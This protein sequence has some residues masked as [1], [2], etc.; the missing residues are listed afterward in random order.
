MYHKKIF[1]KDQESVLAPTLF[2][3]YINDIENDIE[4]ED[5]SIRGKDLD[6]IL[7]KVPNFNEYI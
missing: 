1:T 3:I 6:K 4:S 2:L 7:I 5:E